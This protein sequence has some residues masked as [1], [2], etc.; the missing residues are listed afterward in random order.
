MSI[1]FLYFFAL[2]CITF[3]MN[4]ICL[5]STTPTHQRTHTYRQ[6]SASVPLIS[7]S[8]RL[9]SHEGEDRG[10]SSLIY[11]LYIAVVFPLNPISLSHAGFFVYQSVVEFFPTLACCYVCHSF[12][13]LWGSFLL[14]RLITYL[15]IFP[16]V[17]VDTTLAVFFLL[18]LNL[19]C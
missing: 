11:K 12:S 7:L 4:N 13:P 1:T 14:P 3:I 2:F 8:S 17:L 16:P 15:L 19:L 10:Y 5:N 9:L 18:C 6:P